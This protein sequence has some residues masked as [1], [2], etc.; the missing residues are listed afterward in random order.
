MSTQ[1]LIGYG[2]YTHEELHAIIRRAHAD[3][4]EALRQMLAALLAWRRKAVERRHAA[5]QAL[6]IA[7]SH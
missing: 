6:E 2:G 3:R 4:A 1:P 7:T 5:D